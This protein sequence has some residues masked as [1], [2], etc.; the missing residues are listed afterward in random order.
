MHCRLLLAILSITW[1]AAPAARGQLTYVT[2]SAGLTA[3]ELDTGRMEIEFA[4]I[5]GDGYVD[6][7]SVGDHGSPNSGADQHGVTVW[8]GDD[9]GWSIFSYGN[10][11]YG[12]VAVGDV[13]GDGLCD[14]GYAVHHNYSGVDLGDQL[15]EVA[16]G[17]GT[18]QFWTPWDDGLATN[19]E[20]WGMFGADFADVDNDGDLDIGCASFGGANGARVYVNNSD[21]T[22]TQTSASACGSSSMTF[23][24][25]DFNGDG[26]PDFAAGLG[27][28][29]VGLGDGTGNFTASLGGSGTGVS[30]GDVNDDGR[31]DVAFVAGG[32]IRVYAFSDAA[33]WQDVS[34]NLPASGGFELTQIADMNVDGYGDIVAFDP[35]ANSPGTIAVYTGDGA[36]NW[37][38]EASISTPACHS[39]AAP[40]LSAGGDV[41]HNGYPD[42]VVVQEEDYF[43]PPFIWID[44]NQIYCYAEGSTPTAMWIHPHSPRGGETF[45]AGAVRFI[46]WTA[47]V[48][49]PEQPLMNIDLSFVGPGGP[50]ASVVAGIPNNGRYQ[51]FLPDDLPGATNCYLRFTLDAVSAVTPRPF[52]ILGDLELGNYDGDEDIDS[53]D[54]AA[55][56]DCLTGPDGGLLLPGCRVFD[57]DIDGDSDL[58]DFAGFQAAFTGAGR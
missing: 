24:F 15:I 7:V 43:L 11:G 36:G 12:G 18:G 19:G 39:Y 28:A 42:L 13:N 34:G 47:A 40:A 17:D 27:S 53:E 54:F 52:T 23:E 46:D 56:P 22:W 30:V 1:F 51:W 45:V 14:V 31:E 3:T 29:T 26:N 25:A 57:F 20:T 38:L 6:L 44:R 10:F 35:G 50:W 48:P 8:F 21:G 55:L 9:A 33:G 4:D 49:G 5:N 16:L 58:V 37:Q 41:D 32:G 2:H